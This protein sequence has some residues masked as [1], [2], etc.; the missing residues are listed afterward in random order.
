M[1]KTAGILLALLFALPIWACEVCEKQQPKILKGVSHGTGPQSDWD[2]PII[3]VSGL[4]V[5]VTLVFSVKY[6]V[7]PNEDAKDHI[8]R[9]ILNTPLHDGN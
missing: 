3:Y 7:K 6:L 2:M 8:K 1:K 9:S 4:I 5:L